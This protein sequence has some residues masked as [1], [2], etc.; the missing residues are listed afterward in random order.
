[1]MKVFLNESPES[2]LLWAACC[3]G[4]LFLLLLTL[5]TSDTVS[6]LLLTS[7]LKAG[8]AR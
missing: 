7:A 3:C 1:M 6:N 5:R 4:F 2:C 8:L